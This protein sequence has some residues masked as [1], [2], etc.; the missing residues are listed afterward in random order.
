MPKPH[1]IRKTLGLGSQGHFSR[2][3]WLVEG[4]GMDTRHCRHNVADKRGLKHN[5]ADRGLKRK[6]VAQKSL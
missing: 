4:E 3:D 5:V 2:F 1:Q 6:G